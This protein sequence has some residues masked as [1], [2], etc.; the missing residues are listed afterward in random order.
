MDYIKLKGTPHEIG[1]QLGKYSGNAI[2]YRMKE[3]GISRNLMRRAKPDLEVVDELCREKY[4]DQIEEIV[5]LAEGSGL[6]YWLML[7]MNCPEIRKARGGCSTIAVVGKET[8]LFHNEDGDKFDRPKDGFLARIDDGKVQYT[9]FFYPGEL[10]GVAY[11]WNSFGLYQSMD[12][13]VPIRK[14]LAMVPRYFAA[15]SIVKKRTIEEAIKTLK[16]VRDAS[17]SHFYIGKG[18]RIVSVETANG[19]ISINQVEGT[20]Y[21]TNHYFH[22][23]F[24]GKSKIVWDNS[25][26]REKRIGELLAEGKDPLSTLFDTKNNP[27]QIFGSKGCTLRTLSTVVFHP[28]QKRVIVY[29]RFKVKYNMKLC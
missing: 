20:D 10:A 4:P 24:R 5:G 7:L 3:L 25:M 29:D 9:S 8:T 18:S 17:G 28:L 2:R 6:D 16:G 1:V 23:E 14:D 12:Y 19:K 27:D 15:N 13:V 21:H 11:N 26:T 22:K